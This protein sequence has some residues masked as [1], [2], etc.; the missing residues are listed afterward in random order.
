MARTP[1]RGDGWAERFAE[2][3]AYAR[4]AV[5]LHPW[6][7]EPA[8]GDSSIGGLS[9]WPADEPWP[10]CAEPHEVGTRWRR[11]GRERI[12]V[13][14]LIAP[15]DVRAK[16]AVLDA[17]RRRLGTDFG[18]DAE[19]RQL[20]DRIDAR[21]EHLVPPRTGEPV[22]MVPVLDL[23]AED[24]PVPAF[25][26]G[27]DRLQVLWCPFGHELDGQVKPFVRWRRAGTT[28]GPVREIPELAAIGS[29]GYLPRRCVVRPEVLTEYPALSLLPPALA[30]RIRDL[31]PSVGV[32]FWDEVAHFR[33]WKVGGWE[34]WALI[35]PVTVT[36][37]C[38]TPMVPLLT[39]SSHE[40]GREQWYAVDDELADAQPWIP[41]LEPTG[42]DVG[43]GSV[44][45]LY[46]CPVDP[47]HPVEHRTI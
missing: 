23:R 18:I 6:P 41:K 12:R 14:A 45:Q 37:Q 5:R 47:E 7:G 26:P 19:A 22:P 46:T 38:G 33:G 36:C 34:P 32:R 43:R 30:E 31:M 28:A 24:A 42:V 16:R 13:T 15:S 44:L 11:V 21:A 25:P 4:S 1:G 27:T 10:T 9:S 3:A 40:G 35:D 17:A 20:L 8:V 29:E 2:L 39:I